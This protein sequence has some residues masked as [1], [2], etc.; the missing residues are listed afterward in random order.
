MRTHTILRLAAPPAP[1]R[2]LF[3]AMVMAAGMGMAAAKDLTVAHIGPYS[4]PAAAVA[5]EYGQG[6]RLYFEHINAHGGVDH[7]KL[8]LAAR[9]DRNDPDETRKQADAAVVDGPIAFIGAFGIDSVNSLIPALARLQA[10][11]L[12]PVL[13][14]AGVSATNNPYVFHVRP[15]VQQEVEGAA[16]QLYKL[17]M[18][19]II[20]CHRSDAGETGSNDAV[21]LRFHEIDKRV[22]AA[23]CDVSA[24]GTATALDSIVAGGAQAV[25]FAGQTEAAARFIKALRARGSF[26]MV[27]VTS[28]VDPR[29]LVGMLPANS[30]IWLAMAVDIPNA[31]SFLWRNEAIVQEFLAIRSASQADTPLSAAAVEGFITAKITVEA[32]RR[33][34]KNPKSRD[35]LRALA[36]LQQCD[37]H[38]GKVVDASGKR[39]ADYIRLGIIGKTGAVLN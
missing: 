13:D 34:G 20:L 5:K 3:S 28:S 6:A 23:R 17:G 22:V 39:A 24:R 1:S 27:V 37:K 30:A 36:D 14:S 4:G 19:K 11:L 31:S 29:A 26:A 25:I 16:A 21:D 35:V 2:L 15:T 10:P 33:A 12:G 32:I 7:A 18:R 8:V 38:A 9:D